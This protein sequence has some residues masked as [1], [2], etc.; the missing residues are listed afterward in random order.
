MLMSDIRPGGGNMLHW[1]VY[2]GL[3]VLMVDGVDTVVLLV[4]YAQ[5]VCNW[6]ESDKFG[7]PQTTGCNEE[8]R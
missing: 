7:K 3:I 2:L 4:H 6:L 8:V 1:Y 5:L